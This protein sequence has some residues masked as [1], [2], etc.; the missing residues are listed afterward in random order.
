MNKP[1]SLQRAMWL[2]AV[3]LLGACE[4]GSGTERPRDGGA[5]A[6]DVVVEPPEPDAAEADDAAE[7]TE[8]TDTGDAD[9]LDAEQPYCRWEERCLLGDAGPCPSG[10]RC[11]CPQTFPACGRCSEDFPCAE[12]EFCSDRG[13]CAAR[14][15]N[16]DGC[17][18]EPCLG[19][20]SCAEHEYCSS[21][22]LCAARCADPG[23][24][25]D[26][27][28]AGDLSCGADEYCSQAG[29]C[30]ARCSDELGCAGRELLR[31]HGD[32]AFQQPG[33]PV[34]SDGE[35]VYYHRRYAY[36]TDSNESNYEEPRDLLFVWELD[37]EQQ[38][39]RRYYYDIFDMAVRDGYAYVLGRHHS[40]G[41]ILL[42]D[43]LDGEPMAE[44]SGLGIH[45]GHMWFTDQAVW[46]S[47][48]DAERRD[49]G[50]PRQLWRASR[51]GAFEPARVA[52]AEHAGWLDGNESVA[53]RA[54]ES[55]RDGQLADL[56]EDKLPDLTPS[57]TVGAFWVPGSFDGVRLDK[58]VLVD[59]QS[60]FVAQG[61]NGTQL[62]RIMLDGSS[63]PAAV[64]PE[65]QQV[66]NLF[67]TGDWI[68]WG[69]RLEEGLASINRRHRDLS[70][71]PEEL[72][73]AAFDPALFTVTAD[74]MVYFMGD[75][76]FVKQLP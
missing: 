53:L 45:V 29:R 54:V 70:G 28:C 71:E 23:G 2:S 36:S 16:S 49:P 60:L 31:G 15:V 52:S 10:W 26:Q 5:E 12:G 58:T 19:D 47:R 57:R 56:I 69:A 67:V 48:Y 8:D 59:G 46:W 37:G 43:R 61:A 55:E 20:E 7:P 18:G 9:V 35:R 62:V 50:A 38:E 13:M 4:H 68:Y 6:M 32:R 39:L 21:G 17:V 33:W 24:C 66:F 51:S 44:D 30:A 11:S 42:R 73:R 65:A 3:G 25:L 22:E 75:R 41:T 76:F 72:L 14:C 40:F 74:S 64:A 1:S 34:V 63:A 27:P